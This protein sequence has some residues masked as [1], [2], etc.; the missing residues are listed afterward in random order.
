MPNKIQPWL[1]LSDSNVSATGSTYKFEPSV[2]HKGYW[3]VRMGGKQQRS[4]GGGAL[5]MAQRNV[6]AEQLYSAERQ[7]LADKQRLTAAQS[8][9]TSDKLQRGRTARPSIC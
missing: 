9:D 5:D 2:L 3:A 8:A 4:V 6:Y 1:N 7:R